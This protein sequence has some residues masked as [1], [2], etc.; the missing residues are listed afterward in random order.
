MLYVSELSNVMQNDLLNDDTISFPTSILTMS[1]SFSMHCEQCF[2][3]GSLGT[4]SLG[5]VE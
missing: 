4:V 5:D 2:S 3:T 1:F